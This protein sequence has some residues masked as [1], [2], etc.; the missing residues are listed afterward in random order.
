M[1]H[2]S[3]YDAAM[4]LGRRSEQ[5]ALGLLRDAGIDAPIVGA[6]VV[7]IGSAG[8]NARGDRDEDGTHT[9]LVLDDGKHLIYREYANT[10]AWGHVFQAKES[11]V[12]KTLA[13]AGLPAPRVLAS[14]AGAARAGGENAASLLSDS[15][16]LPL[17]EVFRDAPPS[18]R[19]G[20]W[21]EVGATLRRLH[22]VD[23][24]RAKFLGNP[25]YQ[26]R[27]TRQLPYF[28]GS[29]KSVKKLRPD[30]TH[31]V[32]DLVALRRPLQ[33]W[34]D[35]RPRSIT[36]FGAGGYLPGMMLERDGRQWRCTSWLN[37]G[38]YVSISDPTRDVVSIAVSHREWTGD[39]VPPS[40]YRSY[41]RRPDP[42]CELVYASA[43]QVRRGVA[44]QRGPTRRAGSIPPP[45][46]TATR[47]ADELPDTVKR[48]RSLLGA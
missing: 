19:S 6:E 11:A 13:R 8:L 5:R 32:D 27:W 36:C 24:T 41:G 18:A 22:D 1:S 29:M 47:A 15:G 46:S 20:L 14:V 40:F 21:S 7:R 38:Y 9:R 23:T 30:L 44:Y 25:T 45:H 48:L 2:R 26:Q 34:L 17:E 31:A 39:E 16:G 43:I 37:L 33:A 10:T 3:A 4:R 28:L 35:S 12:F 42:V